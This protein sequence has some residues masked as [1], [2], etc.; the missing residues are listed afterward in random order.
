MFRHPFRRFLSEYGF[1]RRTKEA[2]SSFL[3]DLDLS[4]VEAF[5]E[6]T[7]P[8]AV[9]HFLLERDLDKRRAIT[10]DELELVKSRIADYPI[11]VGIH[12]RFD[13]SIALFARV[14][15]HQF[16][17]SQLPVLNR[18]TQVPSVDPGLE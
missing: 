8:N 1:L 9:L 16:V 3:P 11:H 5:L 4:T 15:N 18:G 6:Q 12:E 13:E 17:A 10:D 7:H 14:L 2:D